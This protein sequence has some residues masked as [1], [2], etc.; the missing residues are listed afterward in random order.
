MG[1]FKNLLKTEMR[2]NCFCEGGEPLEFP[3]LR[4]IVIQIASRLRRV[5]DYRD[6][7]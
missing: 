1:K 6:Q 3:A 2:M 4:F 7:T 5:K